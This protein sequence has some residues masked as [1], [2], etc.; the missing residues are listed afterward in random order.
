MTL[1][2][3]ETIPR[4]REDSSMKN[5]GNREKHKTMIL[6]SGK[7][8]LRVSSTFQGRPLTKGLA[9]YLRGL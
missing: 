4:D 2:G 5:L 8:I 6:G 3:G 7:V 9:W 1:M